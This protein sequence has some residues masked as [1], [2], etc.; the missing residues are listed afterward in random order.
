MLKSGVGGQDGVVGLNNSGGDLRS[1]IDG[2][3]QLGLL[4]VVH[5][6]TLHE[7]G[8]KSRSSSSSKG[9]EE[10]KSLKTSTLVSKL[11]DPVQDEVHNLLADGVVAPGVVVGSVLLAR[12][13][14]EMMEGFSLHVIL[15]F[16]STID[17]NYQKYLLKYSKKNYI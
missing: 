5:G 9:V 15:Y 12:D 3:L 6:K 2:K 16:L 10:Q 13:Q 7:K 14:L 1:G 17:F 8:R 11:P 4:P